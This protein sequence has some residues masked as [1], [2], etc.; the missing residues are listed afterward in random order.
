MDS[1]AGHCRESTRW[2]LAAAEDEDSLT[3]PLD[4]LDA[5]WLGNEKL[6]RGG[7]KGVYVLAA[8]FELRVRPR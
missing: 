3:R 2:V 4:Y 6:A 7:K 5:V 1:I 8:S